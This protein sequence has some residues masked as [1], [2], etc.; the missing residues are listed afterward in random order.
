[1]KCKNSIIQKIDFN[2]VKHFEGYVTPYISYD[3]PSEKINITYLGI[4]PCR[5]KLFGREH[6]ILNDK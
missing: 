6:F 4:T 3:L 1:M 5:Y 2:N